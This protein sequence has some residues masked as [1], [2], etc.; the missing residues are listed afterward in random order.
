M[1]SHEEV[2]ERLKAKNKEYIAARRKRI[3]GIVGVLTVVALICISVP[4]YRRLGKNSKP[5]PGPTGTPAESV[6]PTGMPVAENT[7]TSAVPDPKDTITPTVGAT[8]T[9]SIN[10]AMLEGRKAAVVEPTGDNGYS[11]ESMPVPGVIY[12]SYTLREMMQANSGRDDMLYSVV[13]SLSLDF[14]DKELVAIQKEYREKCD[15][16]PVYVQYRQAFSNWFDKVYFQQNPF[17]TGEQ[18]EWRAYVAKAA[19]EYRSVWRAE[20]SEEEWKEM[21][22]LLEIAD[23]Y[24]SGRPQQEVTERLTKQEMDL[25]RESGMVTYSYPINSY[26]FGALIT[27]DQFENFSVSDRFSYVFRWTE[28]G[29]REDLAESIQGFVAKPIEEPAE[30]EHIVVIDGTDP[31]IDEQLRGEHD[32]DEKVL[33]YICF[34]NAWDE[35]QRILREQ[36]PKEYA[37]YIEL[38]ES[39]EPWAND[40]PRSELADRG[41]ALH[42][43]LPGDWEDEQEEKYFARHPEYLKYRYGDPVYT[44]EMKVPYSLVLEIAKDEAITEIGRYPEDQRKPEMIGEYRG[45]AVY[46]LQGNNEDTSA[47]YEAIEE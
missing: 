17:V 22:E 30:P 15:L 39:E 11:N 19:E 23:A 34:G 24:E 5:S 31:R 46:D 36:Y 20:H 16:N 45:I 29:Q 40:D 9:P 33:I 47:W 14:Q 10:T 18:D 43:S 6:T 13:I 26:R 4:I 28:V 37:A 21:L 35:G 38:K 42:N 3:A 2:V 44:L 1:R 8:P 41:W 27:A 32:A 7:P 12:A 25:I